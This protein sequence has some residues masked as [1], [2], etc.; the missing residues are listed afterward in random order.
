MLL[1]YFEVVVTVDAV[2]AVA[3][4]GSVAVSVVIFLL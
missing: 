3:A 1:L 4:G 2:V